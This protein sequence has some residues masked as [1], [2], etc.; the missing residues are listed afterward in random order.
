M[1]PLA[2]HYN[3]GLV[4]V[5][6]LISMGSSNAAL[7]LSDRVLAATTRGFRH[8][9]ITGGAVAMGIGIWSM[10]YLGMLAVDLPVP[11]YY[12]W[13]TVLLSLLLAI[14][15]AK[16]ALK[17][18]SVETMSKQRLFIGG[19]L[20]A[21][22]I[23]GMHYIGMAAMRSSAMEHYTPWI[24]V[25][26]VVIAAAFSWLALSIAFLSRKRKKHATRI[27]L[28]ASV[29]MGLAISSMHYV[30]MAG[31][32]FTL[33]STPPSMRYTVA[34]GQLG[35]SVIAI[36]SA[37]TLMVALGT[38]T[39]DRWRFDNL[40]IANTELMAAQAALLEIQQQLREAN[41]MLSE[42]SVRDGL[43][44]L[45]NRRHFDAA[46][47]T[48]LRRALRNNKP[49]SLLMIDVDLFKSLNDAYG[50][51]RGDHC[52]REI[53]RVLE[54]H[55]RRGYDVAARYG[56][57]E[58]VLLLPDADC[59]AALTI[60]ETIRLGVLALHIEN[61]GSPVSDFITVSIGVCCQ[62]PPLE[63]DV[64]QFIGEADHALYEAKRSGRNRVGLAA[65]QIA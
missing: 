14:L 22:S 43:T 10:H 11:V 7:S 37:L 39:L 30:A 2:A 36:M 4:V 63:I 16:I 45:Y 24:V 55:P 5:S 23:G 28:A 65:H 12:H 21:A 60:A 6:I 40:Q 1:S 31:V 3:Y 61:L 33:C 59:D 8:L 48:E 32:H 20:M 62:N 17:V 64:K 25:L 54:Q 47:E 57:E 27:R 53:S 38:S 9:W 35:A 13:P 44:G 15:A 19:L 56:G 42:L 58:F 49:I 46:I 26:S 50:H 52:L 51:Q 18:V 29:V 41:A 34:V